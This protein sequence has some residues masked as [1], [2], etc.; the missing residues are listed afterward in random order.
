MNPPLRQALRSGLAYALGLALGSLLQLII[1]NNVPFSPDRDQGT[2]PNLIVVGVLIAFLAAA[3]AGGIGGA[4]GGRLLPV[5]GEPKVRWGY[6]WQGA[7]S[8]AVPN[9]LLVFATLA[10]VS[11][12]SFY[13]VP[14]D[15][16]S[17]FTTLFG[18]TGAFYGALA[19]II[20]GV[21]TVRWGRS[22][23]V[24]LY[25]ALGFGIGGIGYGL[26]L[27]A[28]LGS[29]SEGDLATGQLLYL[30]L[31]TAVFGFMGGSALGAV[32]RRM[33]IA[34]PTTRQPF[35][36]R[37]VALVGWAVL[38]VLLIIT[39]NALT[40]FLAQLSAVL[41]PRSAG[42]SALIASDTPS[43]H[44]RDPVAIASIARGP[45]LASIAAQDERVVLV[46]AQGTDGSS[47]TSYQ[48]GIWDPDSQSIDWDSPISIAESSGG[49]SEP[50]IA[51]D[52]GG[53]A[54][55]VWRD[56]STVLYSRC[57]V[58]E[59]DPPMPLPDGLT[60]NC[61]RG[62]TI[63]SDI[64]DRAPTVA[65]SHDDQLM[66]AWHGSD[67]S[68]RYSSGPSSLPPSEESIHCLIAD[69]LADASQLALAGGP[70]GQFTLAF[71]PNPPGGKILTLDY[72]GDEWSASAQSIGNGH[73]PQVMIGERGRDI[74]HGAAKITWSSTCGLTS[75]KRSLN[76]PARIDR[77]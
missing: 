69:G 26:G 56:G 50:K 73:S 2:D 7:I 61:A 38:V 36:L 64:P 74:L 28:F 12:L 9:G 63:P 35:K 23:R 55:I 21:L 34:P 62:S 6:S 40:P 46:W 37:P 8:L 30:I 77:S 17:H 70:N 43:T 48:P 11:L 60:P 76:C 72:D 59:C 54:H 39:L 13:S 71:A 5:V 4:I 27:R 65:V 24:V 10:I 31:G 44:W 19:G 75:K 45:A 67:G 20:L 58:H 41:I 18:L 25:S 52:P 68:I 16:P 53:F 47:T 1:V 3:L 42:H 29:V 57:H 49:P 15:P 66:V 22:G 14:G 51:L 33:S 32:Y